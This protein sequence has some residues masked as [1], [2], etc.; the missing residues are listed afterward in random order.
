MKQET[1]S[2]PDIAKFLNDN[3]TAFKIDREEH[4]E[5]DQYYQKAS[6]L[7]TGQGGWPLN[8]LVTPEFKPFF[9]GTYFPKDA[10]KARCL[11]LPTC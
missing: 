2:D 8:A 5:I 3:F 4:P 9:V 10:H 11:D 6:Q 1:F 7:F